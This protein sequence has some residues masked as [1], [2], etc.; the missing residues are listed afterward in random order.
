MIA[1]WTVLLLSHFSGETNIMFSSKWIKNMIDVLPP[2]R[3]ARFA[4]SHT[5]IVWL[6][7]H[8]LDFLV[9]F[10]I[11]LL[12]LQLIR[13]I[14]TCHCTML[15]LP[16][17]NL[18]W[19]TAGVTVCCSWNG[20][21]TFEIGSPSLGLEVELALKQAKCRFETRE[22]CYYCYFWLL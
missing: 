9:F 14:A 5:I 20:E 4:H 8:A 10:Q 16:S 7:A 3:A 11:C 1:A 6:V 21:A 15:R 19:V 18:P 2:Q 17:A 13:T 22:C 12:W